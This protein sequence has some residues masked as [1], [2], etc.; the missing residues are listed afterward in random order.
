MGPDDCWFV[1]GAPGLNDPKIEEVSF[2]VSCIHG[3]ISQL[4]Y[5]NIIVFIT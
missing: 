2:N 5:L 1:D 3:L 4:K